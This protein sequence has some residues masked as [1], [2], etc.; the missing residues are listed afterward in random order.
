MVA[1]GARVGDVSW[2]WGLC[3]RKGSLQCGGTPGNRDGLASTVCPGER[4]GVMGSLTGNMPEPWQP[5]RNLLSSAGLTGPKVWGH[6]HSQNRLLCRHLLQTLCNFYHFLQPPWS[7]TP[8]HLPW[9][10]QH[11]LVPACASIPP[12]RGWG[13]GELGY[14]DSDRYKMG[15]SL[16]V[17]AG[18]E[19][20]CKQSP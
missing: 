14:G 3:S 17:W 16:L 1:A 9:L 20:T 19:S 7:P 10:S 18:Q 5:K 13:C 2:E 6:Q 11:P 4:E 15:L 12:E 8:S